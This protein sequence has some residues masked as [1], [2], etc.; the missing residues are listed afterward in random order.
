MRK[1][2]PRRSVRLRPAELNAHALHGA[3]HQLLV[4]SAVA[5]G[6]MTLASAALG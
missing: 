4:G 5:L 1:L 3:S 2:L 6:V